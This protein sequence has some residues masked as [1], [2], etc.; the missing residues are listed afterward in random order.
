MPAEN[1]LLHADLDRLYEA[2]GN[3]IENAY[4]YGDGKVI[5]MYVTK[6][7]QFLLLHIFNSG[8]PLP[9]GE[10]PHVFESF[11]RGSNVKENQG[12]GLGLYICSE[13]MK[14]MMGD[15]Y[16]NNVKDGMEFVLVIPIA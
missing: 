3:M 6:E 14:K 7:E 10:I 8:I 13:I 9:E 5:H 12:N 15:I 16:A 1:M 11:F 4:K 2:V